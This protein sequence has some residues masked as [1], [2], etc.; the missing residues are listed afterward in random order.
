VSHSKKVNVVGS[1]EEPTAGIVLHPF[2]TS[3]AILSHRIRSGE[4]DGA[5]SEPSQLP[6]K[7]MIEATL[8]RYDFLSE[9]VPMVTSVEMLSM[10]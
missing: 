4:D 9:P 10:Y 6:Y 3:K 1:R 2:I 7:V 5:S 8:V